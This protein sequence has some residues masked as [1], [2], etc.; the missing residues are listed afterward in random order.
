MRMKLLY[1]KIVAAENVERVLSYKAV[2]GAWVWC[3]DHME[4]AFKEHALKTKEYEWR[5]DQDV[6]RVFLVTPGWGEPVLYAPALDYCPWCGE[7][8][9]AIQNVVLKKVCERKEVT[10]TEVQET[11]RLEPV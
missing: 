9:E 11:C 4:D 5:G 1:D 2:S 8:I 3:C 10:R 7:K 6:P